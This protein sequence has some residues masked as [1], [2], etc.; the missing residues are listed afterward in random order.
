MPLT[1]YTVP[2]PSSWHTTYLV[3]IEHS[4]VLSNNMLFANKII[5]QIF[6]RIT[7]V[8]SFEKKARQNIHYRLR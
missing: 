7:V 6:Q 1:N 3:S 8:S 2:F 4:H 5:M